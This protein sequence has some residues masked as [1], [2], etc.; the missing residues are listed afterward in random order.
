MRK[1]FNLS[2]FYVL[3]VI[4][5]FFMYRRGDYFF[6]GIIFIEDRCLIFKIFYTRLI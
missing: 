4:S 5:M 3:G 1:I 2:S 6:I